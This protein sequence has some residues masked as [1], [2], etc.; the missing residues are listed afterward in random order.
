MIQVYSLVGLAPASAWALG[1]LAVWTV[2]IVLR[3]L[4]AGDKMYIMQ[5]LDHIESINLLLG[6]TIHF[7]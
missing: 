4:T 5:T 2:H 3:T 1:A 6:Y 7:A